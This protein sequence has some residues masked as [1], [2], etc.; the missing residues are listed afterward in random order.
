MSLAELAAHH[1]SHSDGLVLGF[2]LLC[3]IIAAISTGS[4]KDK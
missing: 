4:K 1:G 2:L 3:V